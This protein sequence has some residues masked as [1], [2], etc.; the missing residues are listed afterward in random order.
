MRSCKAPKASRHR[1]SRRQPDSVRCPYLQTRPRAGFLYGAVRAD[2]FQPRRVT[3]MRAAPGARLASRRFDRSVQ[4][5]CK[6][7][8]KA[9]PGL[10]RSITPVELPHDLPATPFIRSHH[11]SG[12][13][14]KSRYFG[15]RPYCLRR[16]SAPPWMRTD[17]CQRFCRCCRSIPDFVLDIT[18]S[19]QSGGAMHGDLSTAHRPFYR[20]KNADRDSPPF[21]GNV[22]KS[23]K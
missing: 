18:A 7:L 8:G 6:W 17:E 10:E 21:R 11:G 4:I 3:R 5:L 14:R 13:V 23:S 19:E 12:A 15:N 16:Y 2:I 22:S 20:R 1:T 9:L